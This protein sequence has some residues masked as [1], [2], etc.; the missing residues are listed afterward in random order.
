MRKRKEKDYRVNNEEKKDEEAIDNV[1][2]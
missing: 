2:E 1:E